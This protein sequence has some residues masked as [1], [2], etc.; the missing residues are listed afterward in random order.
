[1]ENENLILLELGVGLDMPS[2]GVCGSQRPGVQVGHPPQVTLIGLH[3]VPLG[4]GASEGCG[5]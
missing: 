1:M 3:D 2:A 5:V 4:G